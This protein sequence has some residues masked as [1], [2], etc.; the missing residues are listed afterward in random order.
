M[1]ATTERVQKLYEDY[2]YPGHGV[3]SGVV[4]AMGKSLVYWM[5]GAARASRP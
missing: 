1:D 5:P 3:V 4:A 2:P